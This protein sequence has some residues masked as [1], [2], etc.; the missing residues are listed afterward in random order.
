M[1]SIPSGAKH[2]ELAWE[3]L[4]Y[5]SSQSNGNGVRF[6]QECGDDISGNIAEATSE[7]AMKFPGRP[8]MIE[9]F[10]IAESPSYL[11]S[12]I[13]Q[14][15]DVEMRTMGEKILLKQQT[16]P[17]ALAETQ[18]IVQKALDEFWATA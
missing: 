13:S 6:I 16:I 10:R 4:K 14:Q 1:T 9:L 5:M 15:W 17:E 12:P 18:K 7:D 11:K 3:F 2:W 8:E